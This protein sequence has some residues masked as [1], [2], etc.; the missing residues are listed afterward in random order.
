MADDIS[1]KD[2]IL[3]DCGVMDS[4]ATNTQAVRDKVINKLS[5]L[6]DSME[7]NTALDKPQ[8]IEAKTGILNTLLKAANDADTQIRNTIKVKQTIKADEDSAN[9]DIKVGKMVTEL[10]KQVALQDA[11]FD[12]P[13]DQAIPD[14]RLDD[15][16]ADLVLTEGEL[17]IA[18]KTAKDVDSID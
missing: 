18:T 14:D 5:E 15:Q 3:K 4:T 6:A 17:Q 7:I 9:S 16:T 1:I 8:M 13:D 12:I 11:T 10:F 2:Q